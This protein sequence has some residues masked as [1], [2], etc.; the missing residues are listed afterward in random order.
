MEITMRDLMLLSRIKTESEEKYKKIIDN[1][2]QIKKDL[3][4]IND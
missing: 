1:L 3:K 4:E 2:K